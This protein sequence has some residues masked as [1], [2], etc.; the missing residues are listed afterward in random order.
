MC[1]A[2]QTRLVTLVEGVAE[3]WVR[4]R[5]TGKTVLTTLAN[6][7]SVTML[8]ADPRFSS[9][10]WWCYIQT[11]FGTRGWVEASTLR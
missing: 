11:N 8:N 7:D 10:Q 1:T 9:K 2:G 5:P 3:L 6:N 4:D